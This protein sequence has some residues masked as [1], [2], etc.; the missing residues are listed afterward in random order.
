M[1]KKV[2]SEIFHE[3]CN[4]AQQTLCQSLPLPSESRS[5][6]DPLPTPKF[7]NI[8]GGLWRDPPPSHILPLSLSHILTLPRLSQLLSSLCR[9]PALLHGRLRVGRRM[10]FMLKLSC[11]GSPCPG[12]S[13]A[14]LSSQVAG[15]LPQ[16]RAQE[17]G[18]CSDLGSWVGAGRLRESVRT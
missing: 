16:G 3:V 2:Q 12:R 10:E 8:R 13:H 9:V 4:E 5:L 15:S 14:C 6:P 17:G 7:R 1:S 18:A 11:L